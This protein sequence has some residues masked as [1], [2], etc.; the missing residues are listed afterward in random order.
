[1]C[2]WNHIYTST[3]SGYVSGAICV[4]HDPIQNFG[5]CGL[6]C[7]PLYEHDSI[8]WISNQLCT[9]SK[10]NQWVQT[11]FTISL[12]KYIIF[13]VLSMYFKKNNILWSLLLILFFTVFLIV[14]FLKSHQKIMFH[15]YTTKPFCFRVLR[16]HSLERY[17]Q[18]PT[19]V[20]VGG[21][22][23]VVLEWVVLLQAIGQSANLY[24]SNSIHWAIVVRRGSCTIFA[25]ALVVQTH[26]YSIHTSNLRFPT[27]ASSWIS[28]KYGRYR[29]CFLPTIPSDRDSVCRWCGSQGR[30]KTITMYFICLTQKTRFFA[31]ENVE[32]IKCW[33][34]N[35]MK[36]WIPLRPH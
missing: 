12:I 31:N 21:E 19:P 22:E 23:A 6:G 28:I 7:G 20:Y 35:Q 10:F 34:S 27:D 16:S 3:A 36:C 2:A 13:S 17:R 32:S 8:Y 14:N 1:M 11:A 25:V 24:E 4:R 5:F 29:I 18:R 15:C 26:S 33:K 30:I 9:E